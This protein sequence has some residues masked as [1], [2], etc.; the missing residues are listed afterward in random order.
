M[1]EVKTPKS[2][3]QFDGVS[4]LPSRKYLNSGLFPPICST[5]HFPTEILSCHL[6][7]HSDTLSNEFCNELEITGA[8]RKFSL[9]QIHSIL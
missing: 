5:L 6:T 8:P 7:D 3:T 2:L 1:L 9:N 4:A